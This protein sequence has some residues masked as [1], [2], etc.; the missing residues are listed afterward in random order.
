MVRSPRCNIRSFESLDITELEYT[1]E[2]S[3]G[4]VGFYQC[5]TGCGN[6]V[7]KVPDIAAVTMETPFPF[8]DRRPA[9]PEVY[10]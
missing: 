6:A 8:Q 2:G 3:K 4:C 9:S 5:A 10:S 7:V 1:W